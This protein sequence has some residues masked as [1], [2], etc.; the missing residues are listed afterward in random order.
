[1]ISAIIV[2]SREPDHIKALF[3]G[4]ASQIL[5]AGD[6]WV[7]TDDAQML[8][9][10]RKDLNTGDFFNSIRDGRLFSQCAR[11][12]EIS[13][14]CYLLI[15]GPFIVEQETGN[16][17]VNYKQTGWQFPAVQGALLT[18]QEIGVMVVHANSDADYPACVERLANRE[19]GELHVHPPRTPRILSAG[20]NI[21]ASLPGIG[22]EKTQALLNFCK[23]PAWAL[24]YLTHLGENGVPGIGDGIKRGIRR[25]LEL[26]EEMELW[27]I[28]KAE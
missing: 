10:E 4:A 3:P 16:I 25:A 7:A 12:R 19:R 2:D 15:S 9:I 8:I 26:D 6:L 22:W 28:S 23:T 18:V 11:M 27:P 14:W 17:I 20:E 21:L 13:P 5:D 24:S 1:M